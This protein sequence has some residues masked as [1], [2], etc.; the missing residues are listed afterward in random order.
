MNETVNPTANPSSSLKE[1]LRGHQE[2]HQS[3]IDRYRAVGTRL[4][5]NYQDRLAK[6]EHDYQVGRARIIADAQ[7]QLDNLKHRARDELRAY[8]LKR[9]KEVAE[10]QQQVQTLL[11]MRDAGDD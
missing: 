9:E 8:D 10:L 11:D 2:A 1:M 4:L 7:S 3:E 6:A 5:E